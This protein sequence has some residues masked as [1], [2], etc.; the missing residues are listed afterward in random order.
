MAI[1]NIIFDLGGVWL[2]IDERRT[3]AAFTALAGAGSQEAA[4]V[5]LGDKR[6]TR[7]EAALR[8]RSVRG[9]ETAWSPRTGAGPVAGATDKGAGSQEAA[10]L[11]ARLQ[12]DILAYELGDIDDHT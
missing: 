9:G 11:A 4:E 7:C 5:A 2:P 8:E 10:D 1:K 3:L 6:T 12:P